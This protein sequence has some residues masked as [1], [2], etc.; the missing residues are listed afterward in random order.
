M[1]LLSISQT[2]LVTNLLNLINNVLA[3]GLGSGPAAH[4]VP[5]SVQTLDGSL[6]FLKYYTLVH[7]EAKKKIFLILPNAIIYFL[8]P[9]R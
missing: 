1:P 5:H 6:H 7:P 4:T 8:L 2:A 3:Y 9:Y